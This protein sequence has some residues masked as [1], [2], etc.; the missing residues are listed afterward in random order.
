MTPSE[1]SDLNSADYLTLQ[2]FCNQTHLKSN[3]LKTLANH[4]F[5]QMS[6]LGL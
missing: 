5:T 3:T 6:N 4:L 2:E 1:D